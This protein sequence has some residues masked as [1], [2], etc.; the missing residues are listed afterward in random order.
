MGSGAPEVVTCSVLDVDTGVE[1]AARATHRTES[2]DMPL[3]AMHVQALKTTCLSCF[4][5]AESLVGIMKKTRTIRI[6]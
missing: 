4:T 5:G 6:A 2:Y 1:C 3:C